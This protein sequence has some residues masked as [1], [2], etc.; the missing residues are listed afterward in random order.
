MAVVVLALLLLLLLLSL[1]SS[2]A[3]GRCCPPPRPPRLRWF[4]PPG[5]ARLARLFCCSGRSGCL[6]CSRWS[7]EEAHPPSGTSRQP[8]ISPDSMHAMVAARSAG[9]WRC[10]GFFRKMCLL[11]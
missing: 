7:V 10:H 9:D 4:P 6:S 5:D 3:S 2:A 11:G 1:S 8:Y